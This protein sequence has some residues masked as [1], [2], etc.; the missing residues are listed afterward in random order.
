M[1]CRSV[2]V[3]YREQLS[4]LG[5]DSVEGVRNMASGVEIKQHLGLRDVRKFQITGDNGE[6]VTLYVKRIWSAR[7]KDALRT[8]LTRGR[9]WSNAREEFENL[10]LLQDAAI[11]AARPVAYG[12]DCTLL[13]ERYSYLITQAVPEST[14]LE[15]FLKACTDRRLR[16]R[17]IRDLAR[18]VHSMHASGIAWPD[19]FARHIFMEII[20]DRSQFRL[21]DVPRIQKCLYVGPR[22][23]ARDLANLNLSLLQTSATDAERELFLRTYAGPGKSL[24]RRLIDLRSRRLLRKRRFRRMHFG[25]V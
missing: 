13:R 24:L 16:R 6:M 15:E 12:E 5:L 22:R 18:L 4:N 17:T 9:V 20:A 25:E 1:A 14:N 8:L 2:T 3:Y 21:M 7:R 19:L 23:R 10:V 11:P